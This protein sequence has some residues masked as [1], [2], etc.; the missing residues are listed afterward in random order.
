MVLGGTA[1]STEVGLLIEEAVELRA[2]AGVKVMEVR[3]TGQLAL[4]TNKMAEEMDRYPDTD[5]GY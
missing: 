5:V 1:A 2:H 4:Q 3:A